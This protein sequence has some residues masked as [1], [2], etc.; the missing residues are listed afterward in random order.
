[1]MTVMLFLA[2]LGL[3]CVIGEIDARR[4]RGGWRPFH[5]ARYPHS[6]KF[7]IMRDWK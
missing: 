1:M 5:P 4:R 6:N 2:G 7:Q 3:G